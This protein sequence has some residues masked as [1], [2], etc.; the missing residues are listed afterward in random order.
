MAYRPDPSKL[1][2]PLSKEDLEY[3]Q[4][5]LSALAPQHVYAEYRRLHEECSLQGDRLPRAS[6]IQQLVTVW[7]FLR[8]QGRGDRVH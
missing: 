1:E 6:S 4:H 3:F 8:A 2:K 5:K 7:R